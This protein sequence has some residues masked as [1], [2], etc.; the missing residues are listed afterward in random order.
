MCIAYMQGSTSYFVIEKLPN[1]QR[2]FLEF[3]TDFVKAGYSRQF[4]RKYFR[5][6]DGIV[7]VTESERR[8]LAQLFPDLVD[9]IHHIPYP[10]FVESGNRPGGQTAPDSADGDD[11]NGIR[12][13]SVGRLELHAKG[14][15]LLIEA[16]N[17][18]RTAGVEFRWYFVGPGSSV[19]AIRD[20][21][22]AAGLEDAVVLTGPLMDPFPL[23]K[24]ADIF[25]HGSRFEGVPRAVREAMALGIPVVTTNYPA[26]VEEFAD[27]YDCLITE[28][29]S[30]SIT[31]AIM[32]LVADPSLR[33]RV[34]ENALQNASESQTNYEMLLNS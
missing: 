1:V 24:S 20:L 25:V 17:K 28:M 16:A 7:A 29:N 15:D 31:E 33:A 22:R 11:F 21:V 2:K 12:L 19:E 34:G 23:M 14:Y 18:L 30:A 13:V 9:R 32:R 27:G 3:N 26:A 5:S 6:A 10:L 8:Q 4:N